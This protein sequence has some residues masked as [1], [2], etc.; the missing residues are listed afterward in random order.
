ME[1]Q[2][3][4]GGGLHI[5]MA[6]LWGGRF[7]LLS[8]R[9]GRELGQ[10]RSMRLKSYFA[11]LPSLLPFTCKCWNGGFSNNIGECFAFLIHDVFLVGVWYF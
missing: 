2:L 10:G 3:G 8:G 5:C 9:A 7:K 1:G 4:G 6:Q 11:F